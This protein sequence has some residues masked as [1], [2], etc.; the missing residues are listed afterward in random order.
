MKSPCMNCKCRTVGCHAQCPGY[1]DYKK[2]LEERK[3]LNK[4]YEATHYIRWR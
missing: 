2:Q 1:A 3:R 4:E